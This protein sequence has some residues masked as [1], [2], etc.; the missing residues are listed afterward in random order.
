MLYQKENL[1]F[2]WRNA[3]REK[4]YL[5]GISPTARKPCPQQ[6]WLPSCWM[7]WFSTPKAQRP[8]VVRL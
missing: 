2:L 7:V 5:L 1:S 4:T 3:E 8:L 6:S